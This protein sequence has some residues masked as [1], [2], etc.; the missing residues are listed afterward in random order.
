MSRGINKVILV[1]RLGRDADVKHTPSGTAVATTSIAVD[2]SF[3]NKDGEQVQKTEWM[4]LVIWNKQAEI[5]GEYLKKGQQVYVEGKLQTR[6]WEKDGQKHY[7]T[8]IVV[9]NFLMLGSKGESKEKAAAPAEE[10]GA[11][12]DESLPF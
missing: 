6:Q 3:K 2:E 9:F 8:E 5:A 10:T 4:N 7:T 11:G 1:G 12:G